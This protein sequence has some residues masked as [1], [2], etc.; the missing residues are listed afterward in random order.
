MKWQPCHLKVM[1]FCLLR[2]IS[3]GF[4]QCSLRIMLVVLSPYVLYAVIV[5]KLFIKK[6]LTLNIYFNKYNHTINKLHFRTLPF[7]AMRSL[8]FVILFSENLKTG[9]PNIGINWILDFDKSR[10]QLIFFVMIVIVLSI[11]PL[12][13]LEGMTI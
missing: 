8:L 5:M 1:V 7:P 13:L 3:L 6:L 10:N 11:E 12:G 9:C 4:H 2:A